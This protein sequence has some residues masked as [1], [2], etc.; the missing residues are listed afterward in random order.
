MREEEFEHGVGTVFRNCTTKSSGGVGIDIK[1]SNLDRAVWPILGAR[2]SRWPPTDGRLKAI[3]RLQTRLT[4]A[5]LRTPPEAGEQPDEFCKRRNRIAANKAR[6]RGRWSKQ[7][8]QQVKAWDEHVK[9]H[10]NEA[11]WGH[12]LVREQDADWLTRQR[13]IMAFLGHK[14]S[15]K[16]TGTRVKGACH[17]SQRWD[18]GVQQAINKLA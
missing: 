14:D 4:A 12:T 3:D 15:H 18:A 13:E 8:C 2:V 16:R 17:V 1:L 9:R 7:W 6:A 10:R 5:I 11:S